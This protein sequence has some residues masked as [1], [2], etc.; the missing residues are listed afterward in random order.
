MRHSKCLACLYNRWVINCLKKQHRECTDTP[1]ISTESNI[2][3]NFCA[4]FVF[5]FGDI[6]YRKYAGNIEEYVSFGKM[7]PCHSSPQY[8]NLRYWIMVIL[9]R[10][11]LRIPSR[12]RFQNNVLVIH[13]VLTRLPKP[14]THFVGSVCALTLGEKRKRSGSNTDG[15]GYISWSRVIALERINDIRILRVSA[16]FCEVS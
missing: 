1:Y 10:T 12:I 13:R 7:G 8:R 4:I 15:F 5:G 9:T 2:W 6:E 11:D 16:M 3:L 14:K